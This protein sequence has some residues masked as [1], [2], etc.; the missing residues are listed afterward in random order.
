M[1]RDP[2]DFVCFASSFRREGAPNI[3]HMTLDGI[4]TACGRTGWKTGEG[5]VPDGPDCLV[6]RKVWERLPEAER[7]ASWEDLPWSD[8]DAC[9]QCG[10][11]HEYEPQEAQGKEHL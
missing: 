3:T 5:W 8:Y 7:N 9:A 4:R 10:Y 2:R 1:P 6:C 11:D